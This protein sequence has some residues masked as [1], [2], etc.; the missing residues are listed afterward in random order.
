MSDNVARARHPRRLTCC[1][2]GCLFLLLLAAVPVYLALSPPPPPPRLN[3]TERVKVEAQIAEHKDEVRAIA[4]AAAERKNQAFRLRLSEEE[5]NHYL[6]TD[7]RIRSQMESRSIERAWVRLADGR[8]NASATLTQGGAPVTLTA[9]VVPQISPDHKLGFRVEGVDVGRLGVPATSAIQ[10][11]AV[12][13]LSLIDNSSMVPRA[14]FD[15]ATVED[16]AIVLTGN[17]K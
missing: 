3:R 16:G 10:K 1:C 14:R 17:T 4:R 13:A 9:T 11:A 5:I 2:T 6:D 7:D 15:S 8:V 12:K